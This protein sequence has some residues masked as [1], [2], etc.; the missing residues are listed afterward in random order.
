MGAEHRP[1]SLEN[2]VGRALNGQRL[3]DRTLE[4]FIA[5]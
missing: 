5:A 4:L 3:S 2:R 1:R